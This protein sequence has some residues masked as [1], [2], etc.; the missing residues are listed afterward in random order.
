MVSGG[1]YITSRVFLLLGG[2][3]LNLGVYEKFKKM[4]FTIVVVDWNESPAITGDYHYKIDVKDF[5]KI[6]EK[7][8]LDGFL[9]SL[10]FAYTSIDLAVRSV[11]EIHRVIG[12]KSIPDHGLMCSSSKSM[13]TAFWS[14]SGLLN[15]V[16][17]S[18]SAF[19]D[20]ISLL[21]K[22]C[23]I[24]IKPDNSSSS[25]GIT[26]CCRNSPHTVLHSAFDK[27]MAESS[28]SLVVVEE[29]IQGTEFTV[30]MLGDD[31]GNVSVY[32][33][34]QKTHTENTI[35][36]KIAVKLHYNSNEVDLQEKIAE[37][38]ILCY[39]SL[40]LKNCFGHLEVL[41]MPDGRLSPVEIGARSSGFIASDL[42]DIVS[43]KDYISDLIDVLHGGKVSNG[44]VKQTDMSS[45]YFFYDIPC[46]KT[47]VRES[48]LMEYLCPQI[49]SRYSSRSQLTQG[50]K[51]PLISDDNSRLGY[52]ILEGPKKV[53][54]H[55]YISNAER[56]MIVNMLGGTL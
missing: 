48:N 50:T 31:Y 21:N 30:E 7:L 8:K 2:N 52:E 22:N 51:I 39:K 33:V 46:G 18:Y 34:S 38:G 49:K 36:N 4:G 10:E 6:I 43:G 45:M 14:R 40:G 1:S 47:I 19:S 29:F 27:A 56:K 15:R 11:S 37:M 32:G 53:M 44:L 23:S 35:N 24:I 55:E 5:N 54:T 41:L 13:M 12:L 17:R 9:E 26:I 16:S 42:V 25:R 28:N 20:E 3:K